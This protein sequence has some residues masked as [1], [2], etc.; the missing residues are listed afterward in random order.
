[1]KRVRDRV[2]AGVLNVEE[3]P[4]SAGATRRRVCASIWIWEDCHRHERVTPRRNVSR[5][6]PVPLT[7][8]SLYCPRPSSFGPA[9]T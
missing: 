1:M 6:L 5:I 3:D 8:L 2:A 4:Q 7:D 9:D